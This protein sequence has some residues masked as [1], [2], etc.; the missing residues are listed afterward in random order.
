MTTPRIEDVAAAAGVHR[1]TVSRAFSRPEAVK[2]ETRDHVLQV[3]ASMGYTMSPLAQALRIA[4]ELAEQGADSGRA[5]HVV[6]RPRL[7][8]RSSTGVA[9]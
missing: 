5:E 1:P 9:R 4:I 2:Q 6:L 8:I 7:L 3:A